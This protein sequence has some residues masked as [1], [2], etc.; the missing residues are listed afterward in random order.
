VPAAPPNSIPALL[1]EAGLFADLDDAQLD[2]VARLAAVEAHAA[3]T[4]LFKEGAENHTLYVVLSGSVALEMH[5][6]GRGVVRILTVGPG[7]VLA[8]SAF[9]AEG[10]MTA[11][12][13]VQQDVRL[14]AFSAS[15]L[16]ALCA[17]DHSIGFA[18]MSQVAA[19]LSKRLLGT[20][21]QLLDL[22]AEAQPH[23]TSPRAASPG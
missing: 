19:S 20:R 2:D 17:A 14:I 3:G 12:G 18:V 5:V 23:S 6:P 4:T 22:F 11:T 8:W 9:L 16:K 15:R 7:E 1:R 10:T 21:L 13:I